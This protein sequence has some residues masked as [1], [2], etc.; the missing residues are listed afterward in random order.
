LAIKGHSV[1]VQPGVSISDTG[2]IAANCL[3]SEG[4]A[5]SETH[6]CLLTP[7]PVLILKDNINEL[8]N[9]DP[10]CVQC[11]EELVP[12]ANALPDSLTGLSIGEERKVLATV[13]DLEGQLK[14]LLRGEKIGENK[15]VLLLHESELVQ[16][17]VDRF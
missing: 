16:N 9:G 17:S 12:E 5:A 6:A 1:T 10:E 11:N 15:A 3:C 4:R 7:N 14:E 2:F 8:G 13:E